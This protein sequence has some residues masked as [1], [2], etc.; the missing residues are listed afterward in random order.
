MRKLIV[1]GLVAG[2]MTTG[3][4]LCWAAGSRSFFEIEHVEQFAVLPD[5]VRFPEGITANPATGE[6]YAGTF[7]FGPNA[8]K[9]LRF[10]RDGRLIAQ[11]DF[12]K[13]PLL[14][15]EFDADH[16]KVFILNVGAIAGAGSSKVQRIAAAFDSATAVEDV[17]LIPV[18]GAP[19]QRTIV[20]PDGS[21][22]MI[23][24]GSNGAPAPNGMVF[25]H[26]GNL[27]ISDS[28]Q[29][30]IFRIDNAKTCSTPCT[31]TTVSHDPLLATAGFPPFGANGVALN[32]AETTLF[33]ANTG[34]NRVLKMDLATK[35][36]SVFAESV[37]GADGVLFDSSTGLLWVAAN[38]G[39]QMVALNDKGRPVVLAG[40]FD[41]I[42][43]DGTPRGLLFPAS[44]VIVGGHMYVTNLALPLTSAPGDEPE[45][46]V[47][48]WTIARFHVP[49]H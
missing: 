49:N 23:T 36:V 20:N 41:G 22:D 17:A 11:R 24:F 40:E 18:I 34:D 14:G 31:V 44:P 39:D 6:I 10:G 16:N 46:D 9:L 1:A 13:T 2:A 42:N 12:G 43:R 15:L 38:Q 30:A 26:A 37:H 33:I 45:E 29:G 27:Y 3:A 4:N 32:G 35:I 21:K 28:F 48:R 25:D 8:N 5:G 47:T 7:D 19:G